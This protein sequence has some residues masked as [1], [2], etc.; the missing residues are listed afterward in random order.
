[1]TFKTLFSLLLKH[2]DRAKLSAALMLL[3]E[4]LPVR[5]RHSPIYAP[6]SSCAA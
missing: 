2:P 1:V 6:L 4:H 3:N 5:S